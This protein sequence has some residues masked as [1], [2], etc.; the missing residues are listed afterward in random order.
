LEHLL[1]NEFEEDAIDLRRVWAVIWLRA[2]LIIGLVVLA[3]VA[4]FALSSLQTNLYKATAKIRVVDPN[5][6]AVFDGVQ[7][8]VDPKRD[9]DTQL[10]LLRSPDLRSAVNDQLGDDAAKISSIS[11]AAVGSTDLISVTVSSP[12]PEVA[13]AG[14]NAMATI[15]VKQRKDQE[16]GSF[17]ARADELRSK[18]L[19]LD[20]QIAA[21]DTQLADKATP[22][23]Q[24]DVLRS[25]RAALVAQQADLRTR[26][27]QFDVEAATRSGAAEVA[28]TATVP[29]SPYSPTPKR[30]AALAGALALLV[31]IGLAFLLVRLDNGVRTVEDVENLAGD[32]PVL[33]GIPI[34]GTTKGG[35]RKVNRHAVRALVPLDSTAAEAYRA[36]ASNLRFS[37]LGAKRTRILVTSSEG[38]EGKSTVVANLAQVL[39]ESG[40]RVVIV[41]ADL[42][43]PSIGL[44]FRFD[45]TAGGLTTVLLGDQTLDDAMHPVV[46]PS[47]RRMA[48]LPTGPLPQNPAELVGSSAMGALLDRL[49]SAGA[50]FILIDS[51]PLLPV[52]DSLALSQFCDGALVLG[53]VGETPRS[54]LKETLDR[55]RQVNTHIIGV[56]LNGVPTKGRYSRYYGQYSYGSYNYKYSKY[57][58][59]YAKPGYEQAPADANGNAGSDKRGSVTGPV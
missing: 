10:Q 1:A 46:L 39:A 13:Q 25:Q 5:A 59:S 21:I 54:H 26:A 40:Q 56:V 47:G 20:A 22:A 43:K 2:P 53:L 55:L 3:A 48:V 44:F 19:D 9:V 7:I 34:S 8:R 11:A 45:E 52:A 6:Q 35:A 49:E 33:G 31:G 30:D 36:L 17:T 38:A 42:R 28:E 58:S 4:T 50:D 37:A 18:A 41:S 57:S 24:A 23:T 12:S 14:A 15:Y 16:I 32:V 29:T 51:P 27:T